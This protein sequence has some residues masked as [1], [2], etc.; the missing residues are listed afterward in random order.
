MERIKSAKIELK[1]IY[2]SLVDG[3]D[4]EYDQ[5]T[6]ENLNKRYDEIKLLKK[7]YGASIEDVFD[8]LSKI[9]EDYDNLMFGEEKLNKLIKQKEEISKKLYDVCEK[10]SSKR[11]YYA[12]IIEEKVLLELEQL[13]FKNCKFKIRFKDFPTIEEANYNKNG[14]DDL[15]FLFSANAGEDLKS[16]SKTISGGEMSRFML[17]I[18]NVFA[19]CFDTTT[20]VFDEVDTGISGEIGQKVAERL[21]R[22]SKSFQLIC[23]THLCQVS[24]MADNYI[25]VKKFVENNKTFTKVSYLE[26]KQIIEYIALVSGAE[27]TDVALK[28]ATELKEKADEYKKTIN[29]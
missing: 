4:F 29:I 28:F 23:I 7:K 26:P 19:N 2:D 1:D 14:L 9:K 5:S 22:L 10:L 15:E 25:F 20:L 27:P 11:R 18:K 6:I 3:Q 13:G 8:Y 12:K 24:A 21:A 17:A 16:L